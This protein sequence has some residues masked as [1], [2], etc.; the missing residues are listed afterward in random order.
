MTPDTLYLSRPASPGN[1]DDDI[2]PEKVQNES[3]LNALDVPHLHTIIHN[4]RADLKYP[5]L[6]QRQLHLGQLEVVKYTDSL[7][8]RKAQQEC[9]GCYCYLDEH[10]L[11]TIEDVLEVH[12]TEE[13]LKL[14]SEL[15]MVADCPSSC[16]KAEGG[17]LSSSSGRLMSELLE[18]LG[19]RWDKM[20]VVNFLPTM[21]K[22][23]PNPSKT[24]QTSDADVIF[25][26]YGSAKIFHLAGYV[27]RLM[28]SQ[29]P[30]RRG[31]CWSG[32]FLLNKGNYPGF[33]FQHPQHSRIRELLKHQ[34][35]ETFA[36]VHN[37]IDPLILPQEAQAEPVQKVDDEHEVDDYAECLMV[38]FVKI[39]QP[40]Q[41]VKLVKMLERH[42]D[43]GG[44][45]RSID[46]VLLQDTLML[47][48]PN[49]K[50]LYSP[51]SWFK[52]FDNSSGK[53]KHYVSDL[54]SIGILPLSFSWSSV[55]FSSDLSRSGS[56]WRP[57]YLV[58]VDTC[59]VWRQ[60]PRNL[61]SLSLVDVE[62]SVDLLNWVATPSLPKVQLWC[63]QGVEGSLD[64]LSDQLIELG[65]AC[66]PGVWNWA[67]RMFSNPFPRIVRLHL[68]LNTMDHLDYSDLPATLVHLRITL[69][70]YHSWDGPDFLEVSE[71][72]Q[73]P[74]HELRLWHV[75][76]GPGELVK[77][78]DCVGS[79]LDMLALHNVSE[80]WQDLGARKPASRTV[81]L[82]LRRLELGAKMTPGT[83]YPS[84]PAS[85]G[86]D[87]N[88]IKP[89]K[90]QNELVLNALDVLH[91]HTIVH[92][93]RAD[94]KYP[95]LRQRQ[96]HLGQP[97]VVK[98]T[99]SLFERKAQQ[100]CDGCY[101]Y[102]DEHILTTIEDV[103]EVHHTEEHLKLN[104]ELV[105]VADC[106]SSRSKA[107][108]GFLSSMSGRITAGLLEQLG[109]KWDEM[110]IVDLFPT[111]TTSNPHLSKT[112]Q[113][114]DADAIFTAYGETKIYHLAGYAPNKRGIERGGS[115]VLNKGNH[116]GFL[117]H[118][119]WD[120]SV[121]SILKQQWIG[122]F[123]LAHETTEPPVLQQ[124]AQ[125]CMCRENRLT[126]RTLVELHLVNVASSFATAFVR[127]EHHHFPSLRALH[128]HDENDPDSPF[129]GT[130]VKLDD[131]L[132][133]HFDILIVN[134]QAWLQLSPHS[135][136]AHKDKILLSLSHAI[137]IAGPE[138]SRDFFWWTL[139]KVESSQPLVLEHLD[140]LLESPGRLRLNTLY[141]P[142]RL[143][144]HS[145]R[146]QSIANLRVWT[147]YGDTIEFAEEP[148]AYSETVLSHPFAQR[149]TAA[150][151]QR[152][153]EVWTGRD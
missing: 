25:N 42:K 115:F 45:I 61:T 102:L 35:I 126:H 58:N 134:P 93:T 71:Q 51:I 37:T 98:Y 83:L 130:E 119:Q 90:V 97:E 85:P 111:M 127:I 44:A 138:G 49:C 5:A 136:K 112:R 6:R 140:R 123:A 9:D 137:A 133:D 30:D 88:D 131:T 55:C 14:N 57:P 99:D 122:T 19:Q 20:I 68:G 139:G 79:Y 146:D 23:N 104:S 74:L 145:N 67:S 66:G 141:L 39:E 100:E 77:F 103:L 54:A 89:E 47:L 28:M 70:K 148:E 113:A 53:S 60:P 76:S 81:P 7:F 21:T 31:P 52:T 149:R 33:V 150:R 142:P 10:I 12:H 101:C 11:T 56:I 29:A 128:I 108:G 26:A 121:R 147:V 91:L 107:E 87:D 22:S 75:N 116:P 94:L 38:H 24:R 46:R 80:S 125:G 64:G 129:C 109:Q 73:S 124:E 95:A 92:N 114:S 17:F 106:P 40:E 8:E 96:L 65:Y 151:V 86:D 144:E 72:A 143:R 69:P 118:C 32:L 1:D 59:L 82:S 105:M 36:L 18:E 63:V 34:W 41:G 84:Q 50:K 48:A 43:L 2:K 15:V 62:I 152:V 153:D 135:S 132:L 117:R 27:A 16:S 110:V 120:D 3:V 78:L 4:T 13:H